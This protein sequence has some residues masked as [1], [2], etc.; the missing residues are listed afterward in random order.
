MKKEKIT[1]VLEIFV[2]ALLIIGITFIDLPENI[3]NLSIVASIILG[4]SI[5]IKETNQKEESNGK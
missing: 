5:V 3:L 1:E 2:F 4:V